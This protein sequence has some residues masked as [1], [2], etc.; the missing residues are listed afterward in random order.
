ME[1]E[2]KSWI[3]KYEAGESISEI[4]REHQISRKALYKWIERYREWG[5]EGLE[6]RS[7]APHQC[8]NQV[9]GIWRERIRAVRQRHP[10]WGPYKLY[11]ILQKSCAGEA[12]PSASTIQ[13][14]LQEMGM[15]RSRRKISRA[16]GTGPLWNAQEPNEVW[17][18]DFKGWCRTGDGRRCEP[19]TLMDQASRYLL[20]CQGLDSTRSELVRP[21]M[22]KVF[23]QYGVPERIR[24][25][26]GPPFGSNG[27]C[28]LTELTVW[29]IELGVECERIRPGHPQENGRHER[30]HRTLQE[31]TMESPATTLR[32]QQARFDAFCREYNQ[33]RAHEGLGLATPAEVYRP[34]PRSY[35][36]RIGE[37]PYEQAW[38][39]RKVADGGSF[40]WFCGRQF[41]SHA[42]TGKNVGFE[43]A[44]E[45]LWRVW[46]YRHWLGIWE[47]RERKLWRPAEIRAG[48][49]NHA[50]QNAALSSPKGMYGIPI[51]PPVENIE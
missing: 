44:G 16:K 7:R 6:D 34:S 12:V 24:S 50:V 37:P 26:N 4:A 49:A 8:P 17:A 1:W 21:V 15:S 51:E 18:V 48:A 41:V 35:R 42:L 45:Q 46:F 5:A 36:E 40:R 32:Q 10:H 3:E 19:L 47:P 39:V 11:P 43:P 20:C 30:M 27:D 29:W 28:G 38:E 14:I 25:D 23:R 22:E 2:R 33:E 9:A 31:A 13:R